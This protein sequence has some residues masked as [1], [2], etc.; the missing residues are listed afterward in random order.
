MNINSN[1]NFYKSKDIKKIN[2]KDILTVIINQNCLKGRTINYYLNNELLLR[3][4]G[5]KNSKSK[6][7]ELVILG[8][9]ENVLK[10]TDV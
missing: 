7:W 10:L 8:D 4:K 5:V 2:E 3:S 1:K 6:N 9:K